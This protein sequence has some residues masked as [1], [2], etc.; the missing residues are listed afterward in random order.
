MIRRP[1]RSTLFPY[2]TLFRSD[3]VGL[4]R[5]LA[6]GAVAGDERRPAVVQVGAGDAR[7][8]RPEGAPD[9]HAHR[10]GL[11]VDAQRPAGPRP[12]A[13]GAAP[14]GATAGP[15]RGEGDADA[16]LVLG[17]L[18]ERRAGTGP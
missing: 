2:T 15:A 12:P 16:A 18:G 14:P 4:E 17:H 5:V 13:A 6:G 3:D 9:A 11:Q 8:P 7:R 10:A 1:P